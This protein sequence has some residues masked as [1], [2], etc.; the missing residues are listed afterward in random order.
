MSNYKSAGVDIEAGDDFVERIKVKVQ[1]Q[2]SQYPRVLHGVGGFAAVY[3]MQDGRYLVSGTDGVGTKLK[4]AQ[5]L[6]IHDTIGID[7]VAMCVNDILCTGARPLFFLDYLAMGKLDLGVSEKIIE[8]ILA[9]LATSRAPLIGGETAE[10]PGMYQNGEYD[11]AGFAV[12]EV[13]KEHLIDGTHVREG[14]VLIGL[15]SSGFHSNGYSLL[16]KLLARETRETK[17]E[18]LTPTRIYRMEVQAL[19]EI[20]GAGLKGLAH[21][22]GSGLANIPRIN[23]AFD[24]HLTAW[25]KL[26]DWSTLFQL[27]FNKMDNNVSEAFSTF[28]MGIGMVAVIDREQ[29]QAQASKIHFLHRLIGEVQSGQGVVHLHFEDGKLYQF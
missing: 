12:G 4:L 27:V 10:M 28:N 7:L 2:C 23:G 14:D 13:K 8:G 21:I 6:E 26:K 20:F 3:D 11:L 25:P 29:Y 15:P 16:R 5:E 9:G 24:Y 18:A 19:Q 17:I 22:T 1:K